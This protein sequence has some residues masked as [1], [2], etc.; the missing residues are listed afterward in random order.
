MFDST[1]LTREQVFHQLS[2]ACLRR[3]VKVYFAVDSRDFFSLLTGGKKR[4]TAVAVVPDTPLHFVQIGLYIAAGITQ[5][6]SRQ[7]F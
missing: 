2:G 6:A 3:T 5:Q 1:P 7:L 4:L